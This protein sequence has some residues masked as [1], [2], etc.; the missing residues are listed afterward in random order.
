ML[1][2]YGNEDYVSNPFSPYSIIYDATVSF[3]GHIVYSSCNH[4]CDPRE[5]EL[6]DEVDRVLY[7]EKE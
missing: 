1:Y 3:D 2:T 5:L 7:C 4:Y 6:M